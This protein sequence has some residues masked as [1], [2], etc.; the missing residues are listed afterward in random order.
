MPPLD[1]VHRSTRAARE[2]ALAAEATRVAAVRYLAETD[3]LIV[4]QMET[5]KPIPA[6]VLT[7]RAEA[8]LAADRA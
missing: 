1:P 3:W 4:R 8:R 6:D 5:Q 7:K 2:A